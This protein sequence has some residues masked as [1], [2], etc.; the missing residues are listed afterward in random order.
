VFALKA[1]APTAKLNDATLFFKASPPIATILPP[2]TFD[3]KALL[4][5]AMLFKKVGYEPDCA[6]N[7]LLPIPILFNVALPVHIFKSFMLP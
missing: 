6:A 1:D 5:I 2:V 4:P 7:V 3:C